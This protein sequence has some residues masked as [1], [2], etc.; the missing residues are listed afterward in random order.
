MGPSEGSILKV[1]C[2]NSSTVGMV[3]DF[4]K[5]SQEV[6]NVESSATPVTRLGRNTFL[7]EKLFYHGKPLIISVYPWPSKLDSDQIEKKT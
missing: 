5:I 7:L 2:N 1:R 3:K 4:D 6:L